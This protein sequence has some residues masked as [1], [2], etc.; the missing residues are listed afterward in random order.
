M[1]RFRIDNL[2]MRDFYILAQL[3]EAESRIEK[4][5]NWYFERHKTIVQGVLAYLGTFAVG[6]AAS[7]YRD[8]IALWL[9]VPVALIG[10]GGPSF[11]LAARAYLRLR[12]VERKFLMAVL[13]LDAFKL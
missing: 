8:E 12:S 1:R 2:R 6:L 9:A 3:P 10:F 4:A 11:L 5:F 7:A 13:L